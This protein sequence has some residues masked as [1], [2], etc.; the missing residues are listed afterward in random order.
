M[1]GIEPHDM[2]DHTI[3]SVAAR[4]ILDC[5]LDPTVRVEVTTSDGA[6]GRADVPAGRSRGAHEAVD[7]RD[8]GDRYGGR[9][10]RTAVGNVEEVIAPEL[11]GRDVTDQARLDGTL[12]DLDGTPDKSNLGGNA[13]AGVSL[14]VAKAAADAVGTPLYRYVGGAD[15]RT[16]PVPF[17][18]LIEGGELAATG[19]DFQEH[20]VVPTGAS[21][22]AE[23]VRMCAE[24][25]DELGDRLAA[26]WGPSARNV[27]DEG[28]YTPA[29][30]TDPRD[31][32]DAEL[33]AIEE[34][35][36]GDAFDLALDAAASHL[37]DPATGTYSL[38]GEALSRD[39]LIAFY[40]DLVDAYP[41][42]SVEDPLRED[43]FEGF[44][45]LT[46]S[47]D[48]QIVGDDL[49]A[50]NADRL[51]RGIEAG[52]ADA[53]LF[54]VNQVGTLT[55]AL[56]AARTAHRNGYAVQVSERSGQ[57]ADTWLADVAVALDAGQIKTG[58]T[59]AERTEQYN[60]LLG[61]ADELGDAAVYPT[62]D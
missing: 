24:V 3:R 62:W 7:L 14:A 36:Y 32:F 11:V 51:E 34:L 17:F 20:Q 46:R 29:G 2:A 27:G 5:R 31:A 49:F 41:V 21:S 48:A 18:D 61:I 39:D 55:E 43:D 25:Y 59:R 35:G 37:Y 1:G 12:C 52:A 38:M 22:F 44:A 23:A 42:V 16:L 60:R 58:V 33:A 53:L 50:T 9:G 56:A 26:E 4:E 15:S 19:L 30:M 57:T 54:K 28:G 40:E 13:L 8:G 6:V 45:E 47:L 10:V